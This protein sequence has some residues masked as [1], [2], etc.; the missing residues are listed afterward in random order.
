MHSRCVYCYCQFLYYVSFIEATIG[1][2][3]HEGVDFED[4]FDFEDNVISELSDVSEHSEVSTDDVI[5][6]EHWD[7]SSDEFDKDFGD[8]D[9]HQTDQCLS[10]TNDIIRISL[11]L[12]MLWSSFYGVS[13]T[14]LN[15]LIRLIR[16]ILTYII[17]NLSIAT[18]AIAS[19]PKSLYLAKKYL[20]FSNDVFDKYVICENC[21]SSYT[22]NE[23]LTT[24]TDFK[25]KQCN[26]VAYRDHPRP[27]CRNPCA[28]NLM[29]EIALKN[30][31]KYY[32]KKTYCYHPLKTSLLNILQRKDYL[33]LCEHWR[34][35]EIGDGVL[36][37]IYDGCVWKE[38]IIININV[39][40]SVAEYSAHD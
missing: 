29:K 40:T 34:T 8:V 20:G 5:S 17:S 9:E 12:L 1:M 7:I 27:S 15:H 26:H 3:N 31:I 28:V 10:D 35:R 33:R 37:D 4:S 25:Q 22:F 23:C 36:A 32:P 19:F 39:Q 21:G 11:I 2:E 14:A 18:T 38:F 24:T 30:K 16:H 13:S 6:Q